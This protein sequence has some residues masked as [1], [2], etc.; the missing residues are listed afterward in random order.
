M[1]SISSRFTELVGCWHPIQQAGMGPIATPELAAAVTKSGALGMLGGEGL[2]IE[3]L[4]ASL[5]RVRELTTGSFGVNFIIP[6]LEDLEAVRFAASR[7]RVVEFF[8][9]TPDEA[10]VRIVHSAKALAAWQVGSA[11][12]A[13]LAA[14]AGCDFVI[15]QGLEAGGALARTTRIEGVA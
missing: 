9:G 11:G 3:A 14:D 7:C 10:L 12:E 13:R 8:Y 15:A 1:T 2:S 4:D 5:S 6:F